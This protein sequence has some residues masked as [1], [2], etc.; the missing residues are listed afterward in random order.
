[1]RK[2]FDTWIKALAFII[3]HTTC[4]WNKKGDKYIVYV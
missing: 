3:S 1:M 4:S 2:E